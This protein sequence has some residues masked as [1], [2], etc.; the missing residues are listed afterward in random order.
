MKNKFSYLH[1]VKGRNM[2]EVFERKELVCSGTEIKSKDA[3]ANV[4]EFIFITKTNKKAC[5]H[6]LRILVTSDMDDEFQ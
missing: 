4:R 5:A 1:L 3:N 6:A 2:K